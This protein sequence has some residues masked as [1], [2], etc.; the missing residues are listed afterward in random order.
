M[1]QGLAGSWGCNHYV[2]GD[3]DLRDDHERF[4]VARQPFHKK[5]PAATTCT[6]STSLI[7]ALPLNKE[8]AQI[9]KF[10]RFTAEE[11]PDHQASAKPHSPRPPMERI[12]CRSL[13]IASSN[14]V[15]MVPRGMPV[16]EAISR[17][18]NPP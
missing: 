1:A 7:H 17:W 15:L 8:H 16:L 4:H 9:F 13:R 14:R 5:Q 6:R 12:D 2:G 10:C 11:S 18:L 3:V